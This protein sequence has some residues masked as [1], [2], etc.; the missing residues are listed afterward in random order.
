MQVFF[1]EQLDLK[2]RDYIN[3]V[4]LLRCKMGWSVYLPA[5]ELEML[6]WGAIGSDR[7]VEGMICRVT[8]KLVHV[9]YLYQ[10]QRF[11]LLQ[12]SSLTT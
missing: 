5:D 4:E 3:A 7:E 8:P 12:L 6:S 2:P 1:G 9:H 11:H 10:T